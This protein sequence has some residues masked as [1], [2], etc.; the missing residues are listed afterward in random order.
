MENQAKLHAYVE[1]RQRETRERERE[2]KGGRKGSEIDKCIN[3]SLKK[4]REFWRYE[5][6]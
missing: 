5:L 2:R 1:Y 4:I 3:V 6:T